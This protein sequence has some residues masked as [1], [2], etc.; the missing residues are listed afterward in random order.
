MT[1][2][3]AHAIIG[4]T[5]ESIVDAAYRIAD[6]H[7]LEAVTLKRVVADTGFG[8]H[9]VFKYFPSFDE[10][11]DALTARALSLLV[12]VHKDMAVD[13][14]GRDALEAYA[15]AERAYAQAH[16][17][18]YAIA[19]RQPR[20]QSVELKLL[21]QS[22]MQLGVM[23]LR[24]YDI[25]RDAAPEVA[26]CLVAALNGFINAEL[27]GRGRSRVEFDRNYERLLDML[28]SGARAAGRPGR[29]GDP[30]GDSRPAQFDTARSTR[31]RLVEP[32][33]GA[34]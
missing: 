7:G 31:L 24:G 9:A 29:I 32:S 20:R 18:L 4:V 14:A 15:L 13:H 26:N 30:V 28:D 5:R 6:E 33:V 27:T 19:F 34:A 11:Q 16:P 23:M 25:P 21:R 3:I 10:I 1:S 2:R 8:R 17:T 22:Y 12:E